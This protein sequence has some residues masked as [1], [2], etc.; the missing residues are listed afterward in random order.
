MVQVETVTDGGAVFVMKTVAVVVVIGAGHVPGLL[1]WLYLAS[2]VPGIRKE[3]MES[4]YFGNGLPAAHPASPRTTEAP[5]DP[6]TRILAAR[7]G[8]RAECPS[9]GAQRT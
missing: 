7:S 1:Y 2:I 8:E 9:E 4:T 3:G 6:R 5:R